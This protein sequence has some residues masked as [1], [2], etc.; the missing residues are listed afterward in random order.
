MNK[1]PILAGGRRIVISEQAM[2][3]K[4]VMRDLCAREPISVGNGLQSSDDTI[5]TALCQL[6]KKQIPGGAM[7]E[8]DGVCPK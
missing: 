8:S 7:T 4:F 2:F 5:P 3:F 1:S 6:G